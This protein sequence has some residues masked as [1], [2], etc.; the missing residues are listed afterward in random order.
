[1]S[2]LFI[3]FSRARILARRSSCR[4][5]GSFIEILFRAGRVGATLPVIMNFENLFEFFRTHTAN[6]KMW[7]N[8]T[9]FAS[10]YSPEIRNSYLLKLAKMRA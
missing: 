10:Q 3:I 5:F 4:Y 9:K 8:L 2:V 1:M 6:Q 7:V